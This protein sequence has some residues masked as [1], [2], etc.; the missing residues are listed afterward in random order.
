MGEVNRTTL[1]TREHVKTEYVSSLLS[2]FLNYDAKIKKGELP[3]SS[4]P[5]NMVPRAGLE[6]ARGVNPEGF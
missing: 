3:F 4:P 5:I 1:R 2:S 6:P